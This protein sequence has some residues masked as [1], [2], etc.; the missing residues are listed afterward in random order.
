[1]VKV[2]FVCL[3]NICRSPTAEA[4]MAKVLEEAGLSGSVRIDSAGTSNYHD[5]ELPDPRSRAAAERRGLTM[6]HRARRV[7]RADFESF[8]YLLAMDRENLT[9]LERW[10]P[11]GATARMVLLRS[12]DPSAPSGAEVP[13]PYF[14]G[15]AGF[16]EVLDICERACR[17][18]AE[19]LA[20]AHRLR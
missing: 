3:G 8:D 5:G 15:D 19:H 2:L 10:A 9:Y 4:V 14:G 13:D 11:R 12:F 6:T 20:R 17:G 7:G 18:L 1:V 16:E